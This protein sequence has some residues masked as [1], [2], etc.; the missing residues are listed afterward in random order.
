[1]SDSDFLNNAFHVISSRSS[2]IDE[3]ISR[4]KRA[5]RLITDEQDDALS[6]VETIKNPSLKKGWVSL[7]AEEFYTSRDE[8]YQTIK[9]HI[10]N[11]D[12]YVTTINWKIKQ[13]ELQKSSL[14]FASTIANQAD[15]LLQQGE[16][17]IDAFSRK[18]SELKGRLF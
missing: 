1:M 14:E 16:D 3:K 15:S 5:K 6:A 9:K 13:F 18:I 12:S 7:K 10:H 17:A 2:E 8:A 11:Y 4:L